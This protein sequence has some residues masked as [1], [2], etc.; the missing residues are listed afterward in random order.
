MEEFKNDI[1]EIKEALLGN[2]YHSGMV[3]KVNEHDDRLT[4][5]DNFEK[6]LGVYMRQAKVVI[7][8]IFTA[9]FGMFLKLFTIK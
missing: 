4:K 6:E 8:I 7:V 3:D 9:L 2:Q 5:L 1:K